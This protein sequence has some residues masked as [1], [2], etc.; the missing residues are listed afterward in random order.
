M[1]PPLP[2]GP[3][4]P[5][6]LRLQTTSDRSGGRGENYPFS[7]QIRA[8]STTTFTATS[9]SSRQVHSSG[10]CRFGGSNSFRCANADSHRNGS[11]SPFTPSPLTNGSTSDR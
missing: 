9:I 10:E 6:T 8:S 1:G 7:P 2:P 3:S 11:T 4:P 5:A